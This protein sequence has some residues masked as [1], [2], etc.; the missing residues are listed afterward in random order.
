MDTQEKNTTRFRE[1]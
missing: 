1:A